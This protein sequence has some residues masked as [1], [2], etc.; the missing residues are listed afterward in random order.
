MEHE[1][2]DVLHKP[3]LDDTANLSHA[4]ELGMASV[5]IK[6]VIKVAV[7]ESVVET[8]ENSSDKHSLAVDAGET[9]FVLGKFCHENRSCLYDEL[10]KCAEAGK[11]ANTSMLPD[12][13]FDTNINA[14]I[15]C[16]ATVQSNKAYL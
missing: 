8:V 6:R 12:S 13:L 11:V 7:H 2:W 5:K 3:Y 1:P 14:L 9:I 10:D 4:S 15:P 16:L